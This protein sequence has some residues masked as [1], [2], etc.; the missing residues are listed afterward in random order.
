MRRRHPPGRPPCTSPPVPSSTHLCSLCK[1]GKPQQGPTHHSWIHWQSQDAEG[2]RQSV[3]R[4]GVH[5]LE[6]GLGEAPGLLGPPQVISGQACHMPGARLPS[7]KCEVHLSCLLPQQRWAPAE[8]RG[9][10]CDLAQGRVHMAGEAASSSPI[11][12]V[13]SWLLAQGPLFF[14]A[15][16]LDA[17]DGQV[18][19][20]PF[21]Y[22]QCPMLERQSWDGRH[23]GSKEGLATG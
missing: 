20:H 2:S 5:A 9:S 13:C 10:L 11:T 6:S 7:V 14:L 17:V 16:N 8:Q 4:S 1:P 22:G 3:Q 21:E 23:Q 18:C 19:S 15:K 12:V